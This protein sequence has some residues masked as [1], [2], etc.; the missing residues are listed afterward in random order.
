MVKEKRDTATLMEHMAE[1]DKAMQ[2]FSINKPANLDMSRPENRE[3]VQVL[4][5]HVA[6]GFLYEA[7]PGVF[8]FTSGGIEHLKQMARSSREM[9]LEEERMSR[10]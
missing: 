9:R 7:E 8:M 5:F 2:S 10:N 3:F 1:S 6:A 4:S